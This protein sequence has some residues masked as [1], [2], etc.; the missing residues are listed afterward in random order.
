MAIPLKYNVRNLCVRKATTLAT[1]AA[2]LV[3]MVTILLLSLVTAP[4]ML[5]STGHPDG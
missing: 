4:L 2:S 5:I 3:V 1:A